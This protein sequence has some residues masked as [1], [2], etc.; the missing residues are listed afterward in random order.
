M[1]EVDE[2]V[3]RTRLTPDEIINFCERK[4][5]GEWHLTSDFVKAVTIAQQDKMLKDPDLALIDRG[6]FVELPKGKLGWEKYY[7]AIP[8]AKE[9]GK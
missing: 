1:K 2:L 8:L 6:D 9:V 5:A 4:V 3:E 7:T